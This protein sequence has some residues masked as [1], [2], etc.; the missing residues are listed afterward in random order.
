M[1]VRDRAVRHGH[2]FALGIVADVLPADHGVRGVCRQRDAQVRCHG[3]PSS[4]D[5]QP[6][7]APKPSVGWMRGAP[8]CQRASP[9]CSQYSGRSANAPAP[10]FNHAASR[11]SSSARSSPPPCSNPTNQVG[12]SGEP[13]PTKLVMYRWSASAGITIASLSS[14]RSRSVVHP[15]RRRASQSPPQKEAAQPRRCPGQSE[16]PP[17]RRA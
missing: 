14:E 15:D 1:P 4:K 6:G 2:E 13:K 3:T 10:R 9:M 12:A 17:G 5:E 8:P 16:R 11:R 7:A